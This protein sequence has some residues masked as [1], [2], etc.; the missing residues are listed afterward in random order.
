MKATKKFQVVETYREKRVTQELP[1]IDSVEE[2]QIS[3]VLQPH[4]QKFIEKVATE[5]GIPYNIAL[6]DLFSRAMDLYIKGQDFS[7]TF[8]DLKRYIE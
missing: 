4:H 5:R 3:F 8:D 7:R 6:S 1:T 2:V